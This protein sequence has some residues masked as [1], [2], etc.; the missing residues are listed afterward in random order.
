MSRSSRRPIVLP[1]R[2]R[3]TVTGLSAMICERALKPFL[4]LGSTETRNSGATSM[5]EVIW[6]TTTDEW[7]DGKASVW[8]I[9][10]G[11]GLPKSPAA[12]TVTTSPRFTVRQIPRRLRSTSMHRARAPNLSQ[13]QRAPR[14]DGRASIA[15]RAQS[16]A[17]RASRARGAARASP[18]FGRLL[19]PFERTLR[20]ALHRNALRTGKQRRTTHLQLGTWELEASAGIE[21]AYMDL[22]AAPALSQSY[23]DVAKSTS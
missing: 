7:S 23:P 22:Q 12:A 4:R 16:T 18:S 14:V 6:H 10:A 19:P 2:V 3:R 9:T 11:R 15:R 8:T 5:S 17:V 20:N 13:R 21:P 1:I